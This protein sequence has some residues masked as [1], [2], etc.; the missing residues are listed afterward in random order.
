MNLEMHSLLARM[1]LYERD[2]VDAD[3]EL[4]ELLTRGPNDAGI[5]QDAAFLA[6]ARGRYDDASSLIDRALVQDPLNPALNFDEGDYW[7]RAGSFG[8]ADAQLRHT[9]QISPTYAWARF[10][11]GQILLARGQLPAALEAFN[12]TPIPDAQLVGRTAV[13]YA[14]RR[15]SASDQAMRQLEAEWGQREPYEIAQAHAYRD[16]IDLA[17]PWLDRAAASK[18]SWVAESMGD[19]AFAKF[20]N[21]PRYRAWLKSVNPPP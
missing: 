12:Q 17:L 11:L 20:V 14:M 15:K 19:P 21:D 6:A 10:S 18:D 8:Q 3:R 16:E 9:L 1:H 7:A 4:Q 2:W 13:F 5:L